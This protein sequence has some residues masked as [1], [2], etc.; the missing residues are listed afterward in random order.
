MAIGSGM[1]P[2][3]T[4]SPTSQASDPYAMPQIA[5]ATADPVTKATTDMM[6]ASTHRR[7]ASWRSVGP[8]TR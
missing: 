1:I 8:P 6:A 5:S 7:L 3:T 2:P 4:A